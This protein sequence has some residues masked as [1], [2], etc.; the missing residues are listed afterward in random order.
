MKLKISDDKMNAFLIFDKNDLD[1]A[2]ENALVEKL[3][4]DNGIVEGVIKNAWNDG[5]H[6]FRDEELEDNQCLIA[7]GKNP[8][9]GKDGWL[10]YFFDPDPKQHLKKDNHGKVDFYDLEFV[11]N[12]EKGTKLV[13]L[14]APTPGIPGKN[15]FGETKDAGDGK[16]IELPNCQNAEISPD[17]PTVIISKIA[18]HVHVKRGKEIIVEDVLKV[19]GNIDFDTGNINAIGTVIINGDVKS[20]FKV[21]ASGDITINGLV[22]DAT[23][24]SDSNVLIKKGFIGHGK[25]LVKSGGCVVLSHVS[26]QKIVADGSIMINGE[27]IQAELIAGESVEV[28]GQNGNIIGG[29]ITAGTFVTAQEIGNDQNIKT[30]VTMGGNGQVMEMIKTQKEEIEKTKAQHE[31]VKQGIVALVRLQIKMGK[32]P[33]EKDNLLAELKKARVSLEAQEIDNEAY[34]QEL[35]AQK[36]SCSENSKIHAR[37]SIYPGVRLHFQSHHFPVKSQIVN[38]IITP[39][40]FYEILE[41]Q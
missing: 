1:A 15:L 34:L 13:Q 32:L 10:E 2:P 26:N 41:R 20:G 22:E 19:S 16:S 40:N 39:E 11:Q 6:K 21:T 14:H 27:V 18:G 8:E 25:G 29:S 3:L 31:R 9:D 36:N 12:V 4:A 33:P 37:E 23:I 5:Y 28:R 38:Q 24:V 7:A 30:S 17:E 35:I